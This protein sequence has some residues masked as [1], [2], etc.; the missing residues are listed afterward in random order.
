MVFP[1]LGDVYNIK[2]GFFSLVHKLHIDFHL[3]WPHL[4]HTMAWGQLIVALS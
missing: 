2:V 4:V 1:I 3:Y